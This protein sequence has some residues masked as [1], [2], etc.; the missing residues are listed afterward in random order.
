MTVSPSQRQFVRERARGCCEYCRLGQIGK[1]VPFHIDHIVPVKH[2]G[3]DDVDNLCLACYNCN[4]YKSHD[5]TGFDPVTGEITRLYHPRTQAWSDHFAI[6]N[7][8][9]IVGLTPEGRATVS[10]LKMNLEERLESRQA[11]AE[12]SEYPCQTE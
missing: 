5:L 2:G 9:Q 4:A 3:S 11:L 7:N 10:V 12:I 1:T 8:L 6:R